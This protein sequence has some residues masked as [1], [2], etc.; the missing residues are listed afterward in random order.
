[1]PTKKILIVDDD[2]NISQ[3]LYTALNAKG[4]LTTVAKN[5]E[6]ALKQFES[7]KPNLILLDVLLP[8]IN[9]WEVCRKIKDTEQGQRT[10][11]IIMTALYRTMKHRADSIHKY[12]A[13]D[14]VEKP[15]QLHELLAKI[16]AYIGEPGEAEEERPVS[17]GETESA[18]GADPPTEEGVRTNASATTSNILK[19]GGKQLELEGNLQETP[20]PQLLHSL[21]A[22]KESGILELR[23]GETKKKIAI[24]E[25]YPVSIESN[26]SDEYFGNFL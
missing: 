20:F 15:F 2:K 1:M 9:G 13:D 25:G 7:E 22:I 14:F 18:Q 16:I 17:E 10:V 6:E 21:Y 4:Y 5:G 23:R 24:K 11:V 26:L 19:R 8:K 3:I 12:G